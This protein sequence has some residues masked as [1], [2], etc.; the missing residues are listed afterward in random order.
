MNTTSLK[1]RTHN[2]HGFT[3]VELLVVIAI[4]GVLVGLLLPAVQAAR[5]AARRSQCQNNLK[6]IGLAGLNFESARGHFPLGGT[7]N[8]PSFDAYFTGG[9]PN[10]PFKQGLGWAYQILPHLEQDNVA[11]TAAS[12]HDGS[13]VKNAMRVLSE[14]PVEMYN[15]PSRRGPT[16]SQPMAGAEWGGWTFYLMDYAAATAGP[17]RNE[18]VAGDYSAGNYDQLLANPGADKPALWDGCQGCGGDY[19]FVNNAS[20]LNT[21][22]NAIFRGITQRCDWSQFAPDDPNAYSLGFTRKV[23]FEKI[24]DGSSNTLWIGEKRLIPSEYATGAGWDDRGWSDGWDWDVI[25]STFWSMGPDAEEPAFNDQA[26]PSSPVIGGGRSFGSA[27]AGGMNG[28]YGDGSVHFLNYEI[29]REIFNLLGN[30][31]D[32]EV[33]QID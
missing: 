29:D 7:K 12:L 3:L 23:S 31:A 13:A 27:H 11:Q 18:F 21:W 15:C 28:V 20:A 4:I 17:S 30:R 1:T 19:P 10:G 16:L 8:F 2:Y 14:T 22:G 26:N 33:T 9:K 24:P 25:R 32:G 6:Q 5:E